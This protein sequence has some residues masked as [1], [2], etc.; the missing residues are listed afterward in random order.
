M[1][2][3]QAPEKE[4]LDGATVYNAVFIYNQDLGINAFSFTILHVVGTLNTVNS[5]CIELD[6]NFIFIL[7]GD[8]VSI[9]GRSDISINE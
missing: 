5:N 7:F 6:F 4:C 8:I 3:S 2:W 1:L 9:F